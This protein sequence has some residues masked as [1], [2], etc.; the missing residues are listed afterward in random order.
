MI[1]SGML[2]SP[3]IVKAFEIV[4]RKDFVKSEYL[5]R[6][7]D[8][9]P[10]PIGLGQTVSQP[11]TV[12]FMLER[13][14]V[15]KG[16]KILDVGAGSGWTTALLSYLVG[17]K[18]EVTGIERLEPLVKFGSVN[19]KKYSYS[20]VSIIQAEQDFGYKEGAPYDKILVSAAA[21]EIPKVL[22]DQLK[23]GGIMVIPVKS[24]VYK[25]TKTGENDIEHD[26]YYGFSFVPLVQDTIEDNL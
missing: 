6:T 9:R 8:D 5:E 1:R 18:G 4:D 11:S 13:L 3:N 15:N 14:E 24:S 25:V 16:E 7:Y 10:L 22:V 17:S 26:E 2:L 12:A 21:Q 19:I 20:K 23:V